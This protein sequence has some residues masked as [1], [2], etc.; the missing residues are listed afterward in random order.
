M[1]YWLLL[2][3]LL[4]KGVLKLTQVERK[5]CHFWGQFHQRS[6]RSFYVRKLRAQLVCACILALHFTG[7]RQLAQKLRVE[8][9]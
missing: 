6:M 7:A 9:W 5:D 8:R 3:L 1:I 2:F 4:N